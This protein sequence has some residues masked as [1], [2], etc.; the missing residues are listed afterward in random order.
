MVHVVTGKVKTFMKSVRLCK[1]RYWQQRIA[2]ESERLIALGGRSEENTSQVLQI[3]NILFVCFFPTLLS[4]KAMI[5]KLWQPPRC[6]A[7]E[8]GKH[9]FSHVLYLEKIGCCCRRRHKA[10]QKPKQTTSI[11]SPN[12]FTARQMTSCSFTFVFACHHSKVIVSPRFDIVPWINEIYSDILSLWITL[13]ASHPYREKKKKQNQLRQTGS[14][15]A[16]SRGR[17][18]VETALN[19]DTLMLPVSLLW[20]GCT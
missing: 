6:P 20:R 3:R 2:W 1:K 14:I 5:A 4:Q 12:C 8:E 16:P 19:A 10:A 11:V 17:M 7:E 18:T 15:T 13:R 9:L